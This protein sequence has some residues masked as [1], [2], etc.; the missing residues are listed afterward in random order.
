ME[1]LAYPLYHIEYNRSTSLP[2]NEV[3]VQSYSAKVET[4]QS[5]SCLSVELL[6]STYKKMQI[7]F[8]SFYSYN[9]FFLTFHKGS[10]DNF[11]GSSINEAV[12]QGDF[13]NWRFLVHVFLSG[14]YPDL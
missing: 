2:S 11:F 3:F 12:W 13:G 8:I 7:I 5:L 14:Y 10:M 6:S 9:Q 1:V 4:W